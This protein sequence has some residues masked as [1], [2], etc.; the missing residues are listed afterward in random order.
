[1]EHENGIN[2]GTTKDVFAKHV[3]LAAKVPQKVFS[4]T[5]RWARVK[6]GP[7]DPKKVTRCNLL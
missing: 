1:M 2:N 6:T 4:K 5:M 7:G 3:I